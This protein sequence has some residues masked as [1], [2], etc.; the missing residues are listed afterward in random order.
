MKI[1]FTFYILLTLL[2][3][4][5]NN[6]TTFAEFKSNC[7]I[8][9]FISDKSTGETL[10]G[11]SVYINKTNYGAITN[12]S[13]YYTIANIPAG[14]YKIIITYLGYNKFEKEFTLKQNEDKRWDISLESSSVQGEEIFIIAEKEVEK[15]DISI[16]KV[17][18]PVSQ[19]K[20]IRIGG[21]RDV[22][23]ALQYLPGILT[24]S[25]ISSGLY[26][27]GS[28]PDQNLILLDGSPVYN[29]THLFGFFSTFNTDAIKDVEL[30]KG[31]FNAEFGGRLSSVLQITQKDGNRN[32]INGKA[33]IGVIS[34]R[35][36]LEGP[37]GKGSWFIGGRRTYLDII[38]KFLNE[39]PTAPL[40]DFG[41]YDLNFRLNNNI[42]KNDKLTLSAFLTHDGLEYGSSGLDFNMDIGNQ[43]GAINWTHIFSNELLGNFNASVTQYASGFT[44]EQSD[45]FTTYQNSILDYTA[46]GNLE[47]FVNED[48]TSKFGFQI[49]KRNFFIEQNFSGKEQVDSTSTSAGNQ[50]IRINDWNYSSFVQTNYQLNTLTSIQ[51]GIR[52]D[53]WNLKNSITIDPRLALRYQLFEN[54]SLKFAWGIYHQNL[55]LLSDPNFSFFDTWLPSDSSIVIGS[56]VHYVASLETK[57]FQGYD[58]NFDIYYKTLNGIS[59]INRTS[60]QQN[61]V[62]DVFYIGKGYTYGAEIF[63]QKKYGNFTGWLGYAYGYIISQFDEINNGKKFNPKYDR[64]HDLKIVGNYYLNKS[65]NLSASFLFQSGQPYTGATSR[66][67]IFLPGQSYGSNKI[68]NSNLYGLRLPPSH[69]LNINANYNFSTF[70]LP[71]TLSFDIYNVYNRRDIWF[72][73]YRT[74]DDVTTVQDVRLLPIIPSI[75][76]EIRFGANHE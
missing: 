55:K 13:G 19:L 54:I 62:A 66:V 42:T 46:K 76:Y 53:Y 50:T 28:S 30:I 22:F 10:I 25:Q 70:G 74:V 27:R 69:Q 59:E 26:V 64:R 38:K 51:A 33:S 39:D 16:S 58:L 23:R 7:S 17:D 18:V 32:N 56:S 3:I 6:N 11:A 14:N 40:P 47:W 31:G 20:E 37:L 12:K 8:S 9:G 61:S 34:S 63:L 15:R 68:I 43:L 65:W 35:F 44:G 41:F 72:R 60:L 75:S 67:R 29:P 2:I 71:S 49:T 48:I 57:P 21:E 24:S 45:Y 36:S 4:L 73:F 1:K 5:L 52:A